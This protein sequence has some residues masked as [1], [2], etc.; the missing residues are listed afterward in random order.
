M[1]NFPPLRCWQG[2]TKLLLVNGYVAS[3][4]ARVPLHVLHQRHEFVQLCLMNFKI[5]TV[6]ETKKSL[7]V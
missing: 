7:E 3:H 4:Q 2:R 6:G 5:L 1:S